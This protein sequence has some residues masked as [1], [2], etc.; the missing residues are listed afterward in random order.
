MAAI[1]P[2]AF[3][4]VRTRRPAQDPTESRCKNGGIALHLPQTGG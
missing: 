2:I 1:F 3:A 4:V